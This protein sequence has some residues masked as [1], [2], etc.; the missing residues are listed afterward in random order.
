MPQALQWIAVEFECDGCVRHTHTRTSVNCNSLP[1]PQTTI[2]PHMRMTLF[3]YHLQPDTIPSSQTKSNKKPKISTKT[4][5]RFGKSHEI[6]KK[7]CVY[8]LSGAI[9]AS[10]T[11]YAYASQAANGCMVIVYHSLMIKCKCYTA[12]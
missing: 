12:L 8:R 11:C 6:S 4:F 3:W 9:R 1:R 10:A 7:F 5:N 2:R